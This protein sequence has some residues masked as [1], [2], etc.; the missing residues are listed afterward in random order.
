VE[1]ASFLRL[2][3]DFDLDTLM[4][5]AENKIVELKSI[6]KPIESMCNMPMV[7]KLRSVFNIRNRFLILDKLFDLIKLEVKQYD[8][9]LK[10]KKLKSTTINNEKKLKNLKT[11]ILLTF[12]LIFFTVILNLFAERFS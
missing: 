11:I 9:K 7:N 5:A 6:K 3:F 12:I 2:S 4:S 8:Q 1:I 10:P